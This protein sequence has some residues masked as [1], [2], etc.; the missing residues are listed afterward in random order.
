MSG[1]Q[2][3]LMGTIEVIRD[4]APVPLPGRRVRALVALLALSAD[5]L[6]STERL[7]EGL[8]DDDLPARV[9]G[10]L[11]TYVARL[12]RA[13]GADRVLTRPSGYCLRV[14]RHDVDL[15]DFYD[16]VET[17]ARYTDPLE[18]R[19]QLAV[20]L[21]TWRGEPFGEP[22]SEWLARYESPL[23]IERHLQAV[24]RRVD[25]DLLAGDHARCAAELQELA[26]RHPLR[27]SMWLRWLHAL[28]GSGRTAEALTRYEALRT[29]LAEELGTDPSV[30]LQA[31]H[32]ELLAGPDRADPPPPSLV[33]PTLLPPDVS[34]FTGRTAQLAEL[35]AL[36]SATPS[37]SVVGLHGPAGTGKTIL[38]VHWAHRHRHEFPDGQLF[39]D[40]GGFG[41]D[42]PLGAAEALGMLLG[43]LDVRRGRLPTDEDERATLWRTMLADKKMLVV[44]DNARDSAQVRPLLPGGPS[45]VMVTSR[46]Q[47]RSLATRE[48]ARRVV[49]DSMPVRE[50]VALLS[51]R[52][53][54]TNGA[55]TD[56]AR[57]AQLCDH[58]PLALAVA[59]EQAGRSSARSLPEQIELLQDRRHRLRTLTAWEGD[60]STSLR[61]V[62][63]WSYRTLDEQAA[64]I[65]RLSGL[66][67]E[68]RIS[69]EAA[70]ALAGVDPA[71]AERALDQLA[72]CHLVR[73]HRPGWWELHD[74]V[75][76]YA[77][78]LVLRE[79]SEVDRD[80]AVR[81]LRSW[82]TH[83]A[84][85][86][87][88]MVGA[89]HPVIK[90]DQPEPGVRPQRFPDSGQGFAWFLAHRRGLTTMVTRASESGDHAFVYTIAPLLATLLSMGGG[91]REEIHLHALAEAS[92][93]VAGDELAEAVCA[94]HLGMSYGRSQQ[95]DRARG[96]F[97]R[98]RDLYSRTGHPAGELHVMMTLGIVLM[99]VGDLDDSIAMLED[100]VAG[101]RRRGLETR[102]AAASNNLALAYARG[103]RHAEAL[104]AAEHAA[105]AHQR[106]GNVLNQALALDTLGVVHLH[107]A[108]YGEARTALLQSLD[109]H[110]RVGA[111]VSH[112]TTLKDLGR[113]E[114][115]LGEHDR[116]RQHWKDALE[117]MDRVDG[118]DTVNVSRAELRSLLDPGPGRP[119]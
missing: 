95:F 47:L 94:T 52:L 12:R 96:W 112:A 28:H 20:A 68:A 99:Y 74:L 105:D 41:P 84:S 29:R 8:W 49:V 70:G 116:A 102:E 91:H 21:A 44:L 3:C 75:R 113:A 17:A 100:T 103:G 34:G 80:A 56:L 50:S 71:L 90:L 81:R 111:N 16:R 83:T 25:L 92:A 101:A 18:E 15:L 19:R 27:E 93:R 115:G 82:Y 32:R 36:T 46:S 107:R 72:D 14:D 4:R 26:A 58:L 53:G 76:D 85:N 65:L 118:V 61:A 106:L 48:G 30:E 2:I 51:H 114:D 57:L 24:E 22:P 119:Q 13:V 98:A 97:L 35:D 108:A 23:W 109:L 1:L 55:E 79:D 89:P 6:V 10:S 9:R 66:G 117:M 59:A 77:E 31:A 39:V 62:L 38:G 87:A 60:P 64:R 7:A 11:Q 40:L 63:D 54:A 88:A 42:A 104:D 69:V 86:A 67:P 43:G 78:D 110:R 33:V 45:L 5:Q 73:D 37:P